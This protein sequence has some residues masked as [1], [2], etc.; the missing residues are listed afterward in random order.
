VYE[1]LDARIKGRRRPTPI[2]GLSNMVS[3]KLEQGEGTTSL[4]TAADA[5]DAEIQRIVRSDTFAKS[6]RLAS[7]L[8]YIC[9]RSWSG[10]TDELSEQ[11]IGIHFFRRAPGFNAAEDAIVRGTARHL[12]KR[13][14]L[15]YEKEGAQSTVRISVPKGGYVAHFDP[16]ALILAVADPNSEATVIA[17]PSTRSPMW[18]VLGIAAPILLAVAMGQFYLSRQRQRAAIEASNGPL[19]LWQTLFTPDRR[20]LIVPGDPALNLYTAY[21]HREVPLMEYSEQ[22]YQQDKEI[23]AISPEGPG[24]ISHVNMASMPDLQLVSELIR[25]PYRAGMHIPDQNIEVRYARDLNEADLR[26]ANLILLGAST[27]DP[28]VSLYDGGLDFKLERDFQHYTFQ[29]IDRN[30]HSGEAPVL[31]KTNDE[32]L[33]IVA[34][35]DTP[36]GRE[37]ILLIE[38]T[39]LGS[40][41]AALHFLFTERMWQPVIQQASA[42][43][44]LHNFEVVLQSDFTKD[45]VSNTHVIATHVH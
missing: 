28:W 35:A 6:P 15:Y 32:A 45:D 43:G 2:L 21:K 3:D 11:Q 17:Q 13:L 30:P 42:G 10:R 40:I 29:I 16:A 1:I 27:F 37:R 23:A 39:T 33:T 38:G 41:Y 7:L 19:I 18:I 34:L 20:T 26:N 31:N 9:E 5:R 12:R 44:R 8:C 14:E 36:S 25:V 4:S 24:A 22:S